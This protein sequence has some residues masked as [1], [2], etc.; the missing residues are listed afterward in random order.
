MLHSS[1]PSGGLAL[2]LTVGL[3]TGQSQLR[4]V[5]SATLAPALQKASAAVL[6]AFDVK[7]GTIQSLV[8]PEKSASSFKATVS[9]NNK[10][11]VLDMY[12]Y[13]I[14]SKDH[15]LIVQDEN[16]MHEVPNT[17]SVTFRGTV[18]GMSESLVAASLIGGQLRALVWLDKTGVWSVQ[19]VKPYATGRDKARHIV[20][21]STNSDFKAAVCGNTEMGTKPVGKGNI[22]PLAMKVAEIGIDTSNS[23]YVFNGSSI[24]RSQADVTTVMNAVDV[25]YKRDVTIQYL[26]TRTV[27]R[28]TRG[29]YTST[30]SS[31]LLRTFRNTWNST[32]GS[33]KRD[34]AHLMMG[35][36]KSGVIGV[37]FLGVVCR[38]SVAY[39]LSWSQFTSN[40][41]GRV[42]VQAHELGHN[43][44]APHCNNFNPCNI[45]CS[46]LGGCSRN[47]TSFGAFSIGRIV[48]FKNSRSCLSDPFKTPTLT[49]MTP[50]TVTSGGPVEVTLTGTEMN[51]IDKVLVGNQTVTFFTKINNSSLRFRPPSAMIITTHPV[52]VSNPK[53]T[54]S[55][56]NLKVIG[57]HPSLLAVPGLVVRQFPFTYGVHTDVNWGAIM[58]FS[59]SKTPSVLQGLVKLGIGA[60]FQSLILMPLIFAGANGAASFRLTIPVAVQPMTIHWQAVTFNP[61]NITLP[62]EVSN[63]VSTTIF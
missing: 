15:K 37:A 43:W 36:R 35:G 52:R 62:F 56:L 20:F 14:R 31:T 28:T 63:V 47:L 4:T 9:L 38:I 13:D 55:A 42:G 1:I 49:G 27:I 30:N 7:A 32:F 19:P 50:T 3:A 22:F 18:E 53:G 41:I 48:G 39:G 8:L 25:I 61:R 21:H 29:P 10:L 6:A 40:L 44:N 2:L 46:G 33:V 57:N 59:N 34:V 16:G 51:S 45:M 24:S 54:S 17:E 5:A 12:P 26:I 58:M 11:R 60:N 23:F